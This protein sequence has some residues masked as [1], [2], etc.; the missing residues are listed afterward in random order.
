M[1]LLTRD[2]SQQWHETWERGEN[3]HTWFIP[4]DNCFRCLLWQQWWWWE[5]AAELC[6]F[7]AVS[8]LIT[9]DTSC[10]TVA[11]EIPRYVTLLTMTIIRHQKPAMHLTYDYYFRYGCVSDG[12][13]GWIVPHVYW[14]DTRDLSPAQDTWHVR[15]G[16]CCQGCWPSG[17]WWPRQVTRWTLYTV[18]SLWSVRCWY[19][20]FPP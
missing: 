16:K 10:D 4:P 2:S 11:R 6:I 5:M 3:D 13:A 17:C 12:D 1:L 15:T 18:W 20:D 7:I 19:S 14:W 8:W 9:R